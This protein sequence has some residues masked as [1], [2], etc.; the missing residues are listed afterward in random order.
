[1]CAGTAVHEVIAATLPSVITHGQAV[2]PESSLA[3]AYDAEFAV[4]AAGSE[5][6]WGRHDPA[7]VRDERVA[8]IAGLL[9]DAPNHIAKILAIEPAYLSRLGDLWISGH[10]DLIYHPVNAPE[11]IALCD[12]KT[13]ATVPHQI[14]L[15]HGFESGLYSSAC[16]TGKFAFREQARPIQ[17]ND[18][19]WVVSG[20][21]GDASVSRTGMD[22]NMTQQRCLEALLIAYQA[23]RGEVHNEVDRAAK[24]PHTF[25]EFPSS[26]HYVHLADYVPY[27]RGGTKTPSRPE[28]LAFYGCEADNKVKYAAGDARGP[29]WYKMR[30]TEQDIPRLE[31]LAKNITSVVRM[32]RFF[33]SIGEKCERCPYATP[34]LTRGYGLK[35]KDL[36]DAKRSLSAVS[37]EQDGF[38]GVF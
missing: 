19:S 18:G 30:R 2:P 9:R 23:D 25:G 21:I 20:S 13:G 31:Y 35:G 11:T 4:A 8:M 1:M 37:C 3:A 28:Q 33:E 14:I 38:G 26:L 7:R 15:D 29:A 36:Q 27:A 5:V 16:A 6:V 17:L 12:W 32:G 34:C 10:I 22:L 24:T